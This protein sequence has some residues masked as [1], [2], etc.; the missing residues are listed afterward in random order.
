[1]NL[2]RLSLSIVALAFVASAVQAD[3]P[4]VPEKLPTHAKIVKLEAVPDRFELRNPFDYRQL[5]IDAALDNGD[6]IDVTRL[7]QIKSP[8]KLLKIAANGF[9]R[10][11]ADGKGELQVSAGGK[12]ISVP[13]IVAGQKAAYPVSFVRDVMPA[14]SRLGCNAGTCHGS[15]E[16]K[17]GFKLSLRGY[18]PLFD[19]R[20]LTDDLEGRRFNRAAPDRSL[21]L[22]KPAGAVPH[23]GGVVWQPGDPSY[24]LLKM[25][26]SEGVK[27]D[28]N[29]PR[30]ISLDVFP[31]DRVI[32]GV[33]QKQQMVVLATYADGLIRDV[34]AESF[35]ESS[36]TEVATVDRSGLVLTQ[37]RGETTMLARY[38]GAY[39]ASKVVVMGDRSGFQWNNPEAF[40]F[41]DELVYEKLKKVKVQPSDVCTDAEFIRRATIDLTGLPPEPSEVRAFIGDPRP[42][43]VKRDELVDR[44][45]GS[46]AFVEHWTNKWADM[47][48]VNRKFLGDVGAKALRD[49]IRGAIASNLPYD[50][51]AY[52]IL[53]AS[54]S[55][56]QNG[57]ASYFKVLRTPDAVM[58]NT[59]HLFLAIRF[60]CNKCHDHP[61]ER[62]TQDQYYHLA[63]YFAQ[64]GR[65]RD[66]K[67]PGNIGGSAVDGA[68]PLV[69][70]ISDVNSGDV[71]HERT[72]ETAKP[73]FP[74]DH[75][76]M[77]PSTLPRRVQLAKWVTSKENPYF[78]K[79]YVNRIWSYLLGVGIIEPIDDIRAGNPPSNPALLD[80]LTKDFIASDFNVRKLMQT[81]CKSR[82]Y[83]LSIKTNKW[84]EGD[85]LNYAHALARRLPAEALYDA[86]YRVTGST[87]KIPGLPPGARAAQVLDGSV[88]LPSGFLEL[89]GKP[90][91]ESACECERSSGLMLGPVLNLINGPIVADAIKDPNNRLNKLAATVKD[92]AK[93]VEEIY[94]ATLSRLP[95]PK[96]LQLGMQAIQDSKA[97][98][99]ALAADFQKRQQAL[100][101][102][103]QQLES[104]QLAWEKELAKAPKWEVL[105]PDPRR[106]VAKNPKVTK[107]TIEKD[108][109]IFVSGGTAT[110]ELYTVEATT[111]LPRIT[112]IQL[113]VLPDVR[114]PAK[115]PGL[116]PTGN[117]VLSELR[118]TAEP[119]DAAA[120]T[121]SLYKAKAT[122]SQQG[123]EVE[124]A[125][126]GNTSTG[127]AIS[128][129]SG[130]P[131]TAI[132]E[133]R[134]PVAS[135]TG[136]KLKIV[137][138]QQFGKQHN[139]G[140]FRLAVTGDAVPRLGD[141]PLPADLAAVLAIPADKRTPAQKAKL[142][143]MHRAQDAEYLRLQAAV[144]GNPLPVDT[145]VLGGQDLM[146]ALINN[147]AFLFNH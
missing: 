30:V 14:M 51:F 56:V 75:K 91:R 78:A 118:V 107:L 95:T 44:L 88:D 40:N 31:K 55:N 62:W 26:I 1:M 18:D 116:S 94:L 131:Q 138:D 41:I 109:A 128:P 74:F 68:L 105:A 39:S 20:A 82:T 73:I 34:T 8:G 16:G 97:D 29:A 17:N 136:A 58:E 72:G 133:F 50:K 84:N 79:S 69:E 21:M 37:R 33:K 48:Q 147:P 45:I 60:N 36:N 77:P 117:F 102:Y 130:K 53:T 127:W 32:P 67:Y 83:Q 140:K 98:Y 104:K 139:L 123:Y 5:R 146:W 42:A 92:D 113:E 120:K 25:W 80:Q 66:P 142:T 101:D 103:E 3:E 86:I 108:K 106:T 87:S 28:A 100:K 49:Y 135:P 6:V 38:E 129:Q 4:V 81:I 112:A 119:L 137:L 43:R 93:F 145:R 11:T 125:I 24:E 35:I 2:L 114:L 134:E 99:V 27:F 132:F 89:F 143:Q 121:I 90:L 7:A 110:L 47:L 23:V 65:A 13:F 52:S 22:L 54:G 70:I 46:E 122:F 85:D 9:V 12:S 63:A 71:K 59:T 141:A 126:D 61:F 96:E 76:D 57:P 111:K 144:T 124:K 19:H 15:L 64:V 10:P 115:G